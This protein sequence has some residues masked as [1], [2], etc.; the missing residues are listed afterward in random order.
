MFKVVCDPGHGGRDPGAVGPSGLQEKDVN[1]AVAKKIAV[2]LTPRVQVRLTR[3]TDAALGLNQQSDLEARVKIANEF[4][5]SAAFISIHCNS[6]DAPQAHGM[7]IWTTPGQGLA[8]ELAEAIITLW[9]GRFPGMTIRRDLR[10]QDSDKEANFYVLR[11]TNMPAVLIELAFISNAE[12][13]RLLASQAFQT[14]AAQVIAE[15]T[16]SFLGVGVCLHSQQIPAPPPGIAALFKDIKPDRWSAAAI[17]RMAKKGVFHGYPDGTFQPERSVT[18]EELAVAID[19][20]LRFSAKKD[21]AG[22]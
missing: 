11:R 16:A 7:E 2:M 19:A 18:R 22:G 13:E 1:L 21:G 20:V 5:P 14:A 15:A 3:E 8:D 4:C 10:D 17:N 9:G 6:A 12:E